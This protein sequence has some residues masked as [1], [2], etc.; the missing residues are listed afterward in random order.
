MP[1]RSRRRTDPTYYIWHLEGITDVSNVHDDYFIGFDVVARSEKL[2]RE[3]LPS[4]GSE[5]GEQ[6]FTDYWTN[7]DHSTC[8]MKGVS[9]HN[10][11][12]IILYKQRQFY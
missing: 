4:D 3:M 11:D 6:G 2:A 7:R 12:E 5:C 8:V 9:L 10:A 1:R